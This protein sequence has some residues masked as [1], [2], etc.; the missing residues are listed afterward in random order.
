VN[1]HRSSYSAHSFS[2]DFK[3]EAKR[4]DAQVDLFWNVESDF[5][6]RIGIATAGS[7]VDLGSGTG[8]LLLRLKERFPGLAI[9]GVEIDATLI[10]TAIRSFAKAGMDVPVFI[11]ASILNTPLPDAAFDVAVFRLVLEHLPEPLQVLREAARILKPGG[12]I[13]A[14]DNDFDFHLRTWPPMHELDDYYAAYCEAREKD[15][16]HPRIGRQLPVLL[17]QA[18]FSDVTLEV[19]CAHSQNMGDAL[20]LKS[21]GLGIPDQLVKSGFFNGKK[22]FSMKKKWS[23]MLRC[24]GHAI[25]RQLFYATGINTERQL[26]RQ[27]DAMN[28]VPTVIESP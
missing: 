6:S 19:L 23:A 11:N 28:G 10:D 22:F 5:Y 20:F 14:I 13:V 24:P 26:V 18:G 21:E 25:V 15:G 2:T 1:T 7:L 3:R 4:L 12:R 27:R 16:G 8:R 9:T 17:R